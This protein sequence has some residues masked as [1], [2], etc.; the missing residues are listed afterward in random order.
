MHD[1]STGEP[2][3]PDVCPYRCRNGWLTPADA[4]VMRACPIHRPPPERS[5]IIPTHYSDKAARAIDRAERE[6]RQ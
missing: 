6:D 5:G 4:D 1:R 3:E 2:Y